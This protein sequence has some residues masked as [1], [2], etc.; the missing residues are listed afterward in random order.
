M[1]NVTAAAY[2]Q[3]RQNYRCSQ[4]CWSFLVL[5]HQKMPA[6][7]PFRDGDGLYRQPSIQGTAPQALASLQGFQEYPE[8]V[9]QWYRERRE[10]IASCEPHPGQRAGIT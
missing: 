10:E 4:R 1:A 2:K 3:R 5:G 7:R 6:C 9:W 8:K